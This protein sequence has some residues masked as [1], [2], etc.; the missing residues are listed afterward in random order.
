MI[1]I[2]FNPGM[3]TCYAEQFLKEFSA[4]V[5]AKGFIPQQV[6]SCDK[7]RLFGQ[8]MSNRMYNRE[9][10]SCRTFQNVS[11]DINSYI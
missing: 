8:T 11:L 9:K 1:T 3:K 4:Y 10:E 7:T 6:F 2:Y 5:T